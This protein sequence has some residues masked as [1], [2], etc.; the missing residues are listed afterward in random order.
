MPVLY[1]RFYPERLVDFYIEMLKISCL[2]LF[3]FRF[4]TVL[5]RDV[6]D[7]L[8]VYSCLFVGYRS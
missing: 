6:E 1:M 5:G 7:L 4:I 8:F 3:S 2:C